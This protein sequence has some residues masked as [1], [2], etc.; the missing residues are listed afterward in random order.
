MFDMEY[1]ENVCPNGHI[2]FVKPTYLHEE[3]WSICMQ[4]WR[5]YYEHMR[6]PKTQ[7]PNVIFDYAKK[8]DQVN[9]RVDLDPHKGQYVW[10]Q[11]SR[12]LDHVL[13]TDRKGREEILD[14]SGVIG[15]LLIELPH[16][17]AIYASHVM[18]Q[19]NPLMMLYVGD[20]P[21]VKLDIFNKS[22]EGLMEIVGQCAMER[23]YTN[24]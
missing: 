9:S 7:D 20:T 8:A 1:T 18:T 15:F 19:I 12:Q 10:D 21:P 14:T 3:S 6:Q 16:G 17:R 24:L 2:Y 4:S 13:I 11:K 22:Y 5:W 23:G